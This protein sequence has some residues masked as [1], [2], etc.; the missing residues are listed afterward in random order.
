VVKIFSSLEENAGS[1]LQIMEESRE[2]PILKASGI[3]KRFG[4]L[5]ALHEVSFEILR[6]EIVGLIGPNG[7]GKTTL[8][9]V[10][11]GLIP[12][13]AGSI[14]F[15]GNR[16]T[17]LP[18][19]KRAALGIGRTFQIVRPLMDLTLNQN[20]ATAVMYGG[21]GA[22]NSSEARECADEILKFT[23]LE[24]KANRFPGELRLAERKRLEVAR[25]LGSK[26]EILLL[27]EVF[28]G[29]NRKEID[30]AI[31]LTFR[32]R[33]EFGIT[34]F[35]IE[36]VMKAIMETCGRVIALHYGLKIAD[37]AAGDVADHPEV[38]RAYLG[39]HYAR[40]Q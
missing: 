20:V 36:H 24:S 28:A 6:G 3:T 18:P 22:K 15:L 40:N 4:G 33:D 19:Y 1:R 35:I 23:G 16:I 8:F 7:S 38:V 34:I 11:S 27:D 17:R 31:E 10:I 14:D 5:I 12:P 26:P 37:G 39:V 29:L 25:V 32:I 30:G 21:Y 9:N 13:N 2:I